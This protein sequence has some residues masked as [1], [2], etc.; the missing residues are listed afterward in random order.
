MSAAIT[1][2]LLAELALEDC[3]EGPRMTHAT[4]KGEEA[5]V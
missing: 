2:L 4:D 1:D 5:R 3:P